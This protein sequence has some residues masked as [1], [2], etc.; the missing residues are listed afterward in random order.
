[1]RAGERIKISE[2][3]RGHSR[4]DVNHFIL[5]DSVFRGFTYQIQAFFKS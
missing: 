2:I 3:A 5:V 4:V 1:M